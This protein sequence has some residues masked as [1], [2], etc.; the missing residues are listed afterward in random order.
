MPEKRTPW[1]VRALRSLL[2]RVPR[3]RYRLLSALGPR[4]GRFVAR[5]ADDLGG[6]RFDCDLSDGISREVCLTGMYEPP[7]T[8]I[9]QHHLSPG[10]VVVDAGAN[11]G[12]FSLLVAPLVGA[13]G[14]V[15][16]IEPDPRQFDALVRNVGLNEFPQITPFPIAVGARDGHA[17]LIGY[18][19]DED[20]RG[21]SRIAD[22]AASGR[23]FEVRCTTLD[24]LTAALTAP[25]VGL[26]KIDVE[27]SEWDALSGMRDGLASRRYAALVL[28]LHPDL[29]RA[30]GAAA[31]DCVRVLRDHGYR[32]WTIDL[33]PAAYRKAMDPRQPAGALLLPLERW[34]GTAWPHLLWLAP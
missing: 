23:R 15:M 3:G 26:V 2:R 24:S 30:R 14:R 17:T 13:S 7:V 19:D 33:S 27:G 32:G 34:T 10:A 21:V 4:R 28:E 5:L 18:A 6:A 12:Y 31:E 11:W 25:R 22:A 1:R 9:F 16:A 29:L 20:N 8:R